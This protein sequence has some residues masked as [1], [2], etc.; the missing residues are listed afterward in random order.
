MRLALAHPELLP[1]G[2]ALL[3]VPILIHLFF[4]R[5]HRVVRWAAMDFLLAALRKQRRR[6]RMEDLLLLLVRCAVVALLALAL[7][8]PALQ[9][10]PLPSLGGGD[11][12]LVLLVDTSGSMEARHTGRRLIERARERA[13]ALLAQLPESSDVT[14]LVTRDDASGGGARPL[15]E[16][17][18]PADVKRRLGALR[19]AKGPNDLGAAFR[20]A[21]EKLAALRGKKQLVFL[22]DL[23]ARDWLEEGGARR[24]DVYRALRTLRREETE[25]PP[26]V[27]VLD[28]GVEEAGNVGIVEF[29]KE[30][31]RELFAGSLCGL[32]A[33]VVNYG[34]T[35]AEGT[36]V[37]YMA[38]AED[39]TWEKKTAEPVRLRRTLGAGEP[40]SAS[41]PLYLPLPP[42]S[43]GPARFK[44]TFEGAG[45]ADRLEAD[46]E[47]FLA[48]AVRPRVRFLPVRSS[49]GAL[50]VLRDTEV[51]G[52]LEL[53]PPIL[54]E[55]LSTADLSGVDVVLWADA[56]THG[57]DERGAK[58]LEA[59]VRRGGGFLAY[60]GNY[61][62][63]EKLNRLFHAE[64]GLGLFPMR[65]REHGLVDVSAAPVAVDVSR[66][67]PHPLFREM[68]ATDKARAL[69]FSPEVERFRAVDEP[70]EGSVVARY[71]TPGADPA[72]LVHALGRGRVVLVTTTPD[73]TGFRLNGSLLPAVFFFEAAHYLVA[74][75]VADRNVSVGRPV[76]VALP[77][78]ARQVSVEP[79]AE[80]GGRTEEPVED[81]AKPFVLSDTAVPGFY[82][83]TVRSS[84]PAGA[85]AP[86]DEVHLASVSFDAAE[87]DLRRAERDA[88]QRLFPGVA[89]RFSEEADAA[90]PRG[91]G[92]ADGE[93]SRALLLAVA[94]LLFV[95][96]LLAWRFGRRRRTAP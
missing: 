49:G 10:A 93:I 24:E 92:D 1:I 51:T 5:R 11:R 56:E 81:A 9:A 70:L 78:L 50:D 58:N 54:P 36:L 19:T 62:A 46:S 83:I 33:R 8:R 30:D 27:T 31:G 41:P 37:L 64:K 17:A 43:E 94:A 75:P 22:T 28:V 89:M 40:S 4:R 29:T 2:G 55:E 57:L 15:L 32:V 77:P 79:P 87:S 3:L 88:L 45:G 61:A 66:P 65:L 34:P 26:P 95:E 25:D 76:R 63:P 84:A 69:F 52:V 80:A 23:Q 68:T 13:D 48:L 59:F 14:L 86:P 67:I 21:G 38:R 44:V 42:G 39:G 71:T 73:E 90:L 72:V 91:A 47:R 7:A 60:L 74:E 82:R 16:N 85:P 96:L 6:L 35:E 18:R 53:R 12:Q 20:L